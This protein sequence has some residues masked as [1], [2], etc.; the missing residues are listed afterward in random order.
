MRLLSWLCALFVAANLLGCRQHASL[1][2]RNRPIGVPSTAVWA[3]G[4]DG[5]CYVQ[6]SIDKERNVNH[7]NVWND[8]TGE[9]ATSGDFRLI[10][11]NRPASQ[12]ELIFKGAIN[13]FIYLRNGLTLKRV[14][15]PGQATEK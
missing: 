7:C 3:G 8:F 4:A 9:L 6:C 14:A 10:D 11:Q 15:G 1:E 2:P 13:E 12:S 5:G